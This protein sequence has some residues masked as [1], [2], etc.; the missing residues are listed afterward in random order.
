[1]IPESTFSGCSDLVS[2]TLGDR[3]AAVDVNAFSGCSSLK[4]V[5][6]SGTAEDFSYIIMA[7][8]NDALKNAYG[9]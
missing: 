1:M 7:P 2:I 9:G 3:V 6:Y 4:T 5:E 8:G